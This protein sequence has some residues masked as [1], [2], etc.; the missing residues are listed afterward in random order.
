M[1]QTP[2]LSLPLPHRLK[3]LLGTSLLLLLALSFYVSMPLFVLLTPK[4]E[5]TTWFPRKIRCAPCA[6][7][8]R[9][10]MRLAEK[11]CVA[12]AWDGEGT[13][14][15]GVTSRYNATRVEMGEGKER[16]LP[17]GVGGVLG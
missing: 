13:V 11:V 10:N 17:G 16:V 9:E 14:R 12:S 4:Q 7:I 1:P 8:A 3:I 15:G 2:I 5:L 6:D